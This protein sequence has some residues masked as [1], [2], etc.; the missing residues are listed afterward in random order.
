MSEKY[1]KRTK[2]GKGRKRKEFVKEVREFRIKIKPVI[3]VALS[4]MVIEAL[5]EKERKKDA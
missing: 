1:I 3:N 5:K 2:K 4:L